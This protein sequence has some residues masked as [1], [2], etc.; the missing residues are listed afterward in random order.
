MKYKLLIL[1]LLLASLSHGQCVGNCT[2]VSGTLV[3]SSGQVWSNAILT[4]KIVPKF[5]SVGPLLNNGVPI[6][7]PIN[8]IIANGSGA[9]SISLDSNNQVFPAGSTW[10]FTICPN[11]TVSNCGSISLFIF[12]ATENVSSALN[13]FIS[14]PV[15]S[16]APTINRAY[17]DAE[18][19][20]GLGSLYWRT[21]DNELRGCAVLLCNGT[22]WIAVGAGGGSI[23][24]GTTNQ[25]LV[26]TGTNSVGGQD[27]LIV[28]IRD[29]SAAA[30]S[31][32]ATCNGITDD[33]AAIQAYLNYYGAGGIGANNNVEL[34][35]P[36]GLCKISNQ[37]VFE[38]S[39]S[40]GIRLVGVKGQ[41]GG[42]NGSN[43]GWWGP[44]FGTM[45]LFLGCN[46]C[47]TENIDFLLNEVG[48]GGGKAQ[49]GVWYDASN[50]IST[51][52]SYNMS[53]ISRSGYVV[54]ATTTASHV[55]TAGRIVKVA[56]STGGATSFN[57]TFQVQYTNDNTHIS[58]FQT[59]ANESGTASTGT[60]TNYKSSPSNNLKMSSVQISNPQGVNSTITSITGTSPTWTITTAT[61]HFAFLGDTV[62]ARGG[63]DPTYNCA[64]I[65]TAIPTST[66]ATAVVLPGTQCGPSGS[67]STGGTLTSGSSGI[68]IGHRD[69]ATEQVSSINF[70]DIFI[71]GDQLG[72]SVNCIENDG[73]GNVKD[74]IFDYLLFNGCRYGMSGFTSGQLSVYGYIGGLVTPDVTPQLAAID[75]V[76]NVGQI[77]IQG[78]E[79]EGQNYRFFVSSGSPGSCNVHLDGI[80]FQGAAPTDDIEVVSSCATTITN[81]LFGNNR[82][83]GSAPFIQMGNPLLGNNTSSLISEGNT[84]TNTAAGCTGPSCGWVPVKD[85]SGNIFHA[86]GGS[87]YDGKD[88]NITSIGDHGTITNGF[89]NTKPLTIALPGFNTGGQIVSTF[90]T[91]APFSVASIVPVNNLSLGGGVGTSVN[92]AALTL[93]SV[94]GS[95]QCLHANASGVVTG[96]GADCPGGGGG[97]GLPASP[98]I[99]DTIRY[100]INGDTLWD[101]SNIGRSVQMVSDGGNVLLVGSAV[102]PASVAGSSGPTGVNA[103]A[104]DTAGAKWSSA[105]TASLNSLIGEWN[106]TGGNSGIYSFG[107]FYRWT[108][109][110]SAQNTTNVRY[111]MGLTT[112][113]N[114]GPGTEGQTINGTAKMAVDTLNSSSLAFR[115]SAGTDTTWKAVAVTTG[116]SQSLLDTA[117]VMDTNPHKF[118]ITYDGTMAHYY[119]DGVSVAAISTNTPAATALGMFPFWCGDNKNTATSV[120]GTLFYM[121]LSLK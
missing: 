48:N 25:Q 107:S 59:G 22:G 76:N 109:R 112:Y 9:F 1:F 117:V 120:A 30:L 2:T 102:G 34:Q 73:A 87:F 6:N 121:T 98:Q 24:A 46:S 21:T 114:G 116:G 115:F 113:N 19:T 78:A 12:G 50:T 81:S 79:S 99:G 52:V 71:Q 26:Y 91:G 75:F 62:I 74:F 95:N 94:T 8:N 57:G 111:W 110:W 40:I 51:S 53:A 104:T 31:T 45:L 37:L 54:T 96:T 93:S 36:V 83:S 69:S 29:P 55:V 38:G 4:I 10:Q 17:V 56:G 39:N 106:G 14:T 118:D 33:T 49:N 32:G 47:S 61:S 108:M 3:D 43:I 89:G 23:P 88:T 101:S 7:S 90:S 65:T 119:I 97:T 44:N 27:K 64:Y 70:K 92:T 13:T 60:V 5:G 18:A 68:R 103:T 42:V 16:T 82:A 11:A 58:W 63:S 41:N 85:G 77:F 100:N 105:A 28:D 67:N 80:S 72:G 35:F 84:Y 66:T 20:G 86:T 15:V